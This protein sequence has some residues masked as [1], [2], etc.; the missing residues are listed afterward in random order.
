MLVFLCFGFD[1]LLRVLVFTVVTWI[2]YCFALFLFDLLSVI[3][4]LVQCITVGFTFMLRVDRLLC[5]LTASVGGLFGSG[6]Y[7]YLVCVGF[8]DF[9]A[10]C[11]LVCGF[12]PGWGWDVMFGG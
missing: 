3:V 10:G 4:G 5:W 6:S 1:L 9:D 8:V 11:C 12:E 7:G 2:V